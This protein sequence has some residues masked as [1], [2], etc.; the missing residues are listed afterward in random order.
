MQVTL[1]GGMDRLG[2]HYHE[3]ARKAGVELRIYSQAKTSFDKKISGS[4]VVV[5]FTGNI[6]HHAREIVIQVARAHAIPVYQFH[7][8]GICTLRKCLNCLNKTNSRL[9]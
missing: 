3:T 7:S 8:C 1:I 6:S 5:L 9:G 2:R 4:Q